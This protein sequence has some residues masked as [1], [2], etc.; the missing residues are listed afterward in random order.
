MLT[1]SALFEKLMNQGP[2]VVKPSRIAPLKTAVKQYASMLGSSPE[3]CWPDRYHL[4]DK[5]RNALIETHANPELS[6]HAI[7]NLKDNV[8]FL[9]HVGEQLQLL[10]PL[11]Q[12][13]L[14]S[15]RNRHQLT[16]ETP[17]PYSCEWPKRQPYSLHPLP[18]QLA[19]EVQAYEDW[20]TKDFA[21]DRPAYLKKRPVT[22]IAHRGAISHMAGFLVYEQGRD[23]NELTLRDLINPASVEAFVSWWVQG[24]GKVTRTIYEKLQILLVIARHRYKD[25]ASATV[26][27]HIKSLLPK[28]SKVFDP[29]K[30]SLP[31]PELEA[32]GRS[33]YPLNA[34]RLQEY[35][36]ANRGKQLEVARKSPRPWLNGRRLAV[37]VEYSLIIRLLTRHPIRIRNVV[38]MQLGSNLFQLPDGR[39]R[40]RFTGK[41]LKVAERRGKENELTFIW[42]ED[43]RELLEEWLTQWRPVLLQGEDPG[44]V[45]LSKRGKPYDTGILREGIKRTTWKFT[46]VTVTPH[47]F[48]HIWA[49]E[50][51]KS[52]GK[53]HVAARRLG[54]TV[55]MIHRHYAHLLD[56]EADREADEW[57][58]RRLQRCVQDK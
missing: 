12:E 13:S 40:V 35:H 57:I 43:L 42:P 25:E 18:P 41:Q 3:H 24:R 50:H 39:W 16:R 23:A 21:A 4:P 27:Q 56:E 20:S 10:Q 49:T 30:H 52:G 7:R 28:P 47:M 11:A 5:E 8:R 33:I 58:A 14:K 15:W 9:L 2:T 55:D 44:H 31:I 38:E 36:R 29:N 1:L 54:N 46:G 37:W 19:A 48:R 26:I 45:F 22:M 32:I 6:Y 34:R 17:K 53:A 51:L